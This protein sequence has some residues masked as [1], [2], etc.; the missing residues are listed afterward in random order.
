MKWQRKVGLADEEKFL[1]LPKYLKKADVKE[2]F[3]LLLL[4]FYEQNHYLI[5]KR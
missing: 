1:E 5:S 2:R 3:P 4:E